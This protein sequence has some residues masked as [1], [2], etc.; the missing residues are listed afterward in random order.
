M[1]GAKP[2]LKKLLAQAYENLNETESASKI[3]DSYLKTAGNDSAAFYAAGNLH[4]NRGEYKKA[5]ESLLQAQVLMP[6]NFDV[7]CKLGESYYRA[8]KLTEAVAAFVSARSINSRELKVI[9]ALAHC[10]RQL[11]DIPNMIIALREGL[12]LEE[13]NLEVKAGLGK[14]LLEQH[15]TTEALRYLEQVSRRKPEDV[16]LHLLLARTYKQLG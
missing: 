9:K 6:K 4:F 2:E 16:D 7:A 1:P 3:Y 11:N 13:N 12:Y 10:Y 8:G 15:N 5:I 14:A